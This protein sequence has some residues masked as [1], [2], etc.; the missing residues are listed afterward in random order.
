M[1]IITIEGP[2]VED[3]Q[4]KRDFVKE[5][6]KTTASYFNMPEESIIILIRENEPQNVSVGGRLIIDKNRK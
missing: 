6:T 2:K 5:I 4:K 1:P 3:I